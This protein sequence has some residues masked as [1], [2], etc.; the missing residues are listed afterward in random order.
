MPYELRLL[1]E[2]TRD[3]ERLDRT[4]GRRIANRLEWLR[5]NFENI[6][7]EALTGSLTGFYKFRIGDYRAIYEILRAEGTIV[8]SY[9]R[10]SQQDISQEVIVPLSR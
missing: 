4:V 10:S 9:D 6:T 1:E 8:V 2:A 3:L 5:N 7:P